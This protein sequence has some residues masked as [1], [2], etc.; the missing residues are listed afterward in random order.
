MLSS[1]FFFAA[2][3]LLLGSTLLCAQQTVT[4]GITTLV[5]V[6]SPTYKS[7]PGHL[8]PSQARRDDTTIVIE[9]NPFYGLPPIMHP[10]VLSSSTTPS[11][12]LSSTSSSSA[13]SPIPS[14]AESS[15]SYSTMSATLSERCDH[16]NCFRQFI[17][18]SY[19]LSPFCETFTTTTN[20][21]IDQLPTYASQ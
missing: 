10:H 11:L 17:R 5:T 13:K 4:V 14:S 9:E 6:A 8:A 1:T 2:L 16:D 3:L 15:V 20:T 21:A 19:V 18:S 12:S 7:S